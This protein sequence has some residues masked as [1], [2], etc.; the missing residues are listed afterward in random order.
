MWI[1]S[2]YENFEN[3]TGFIHGHIVNSGHVHVYIHCITGALNPQ[4][5]S[6]VPVDSTRSITM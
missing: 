3:L 5:S 4:C 1:S 2:R 6:N